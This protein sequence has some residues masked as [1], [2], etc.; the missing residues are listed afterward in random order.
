M[1]KLPKSFYQRS[2][3][4]SAKDFL[5]KYLVHKTSRGII[6][7]MITEV[8]AYPAFSDEVSHGNKRTGR[9][10][11]LYKEGGYA[12]VYLVYGL[13][14]QFALVVN[15]KDTP[16]VVFIRALEP[17]EGVGLMQHN[18]GK[19]I[20][21]TKLTASPG[22]LCKAFGITREHCGIDVTGDTLFIEDHGIPIDNNDIFEGK[23]IGI[24][25][26]LKG[27]E[28]ALRFTLKKQ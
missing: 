16:E 2:A 5:G 21:I 1:P 10:E 3:A 14:H 11:V 26:R 9:T 13:H 15:K 8:E 28:N 18:F 17:K 25:Q 12:Y 7:G 4:D 24:S 6:S 19:K 20:P 23:R 22:N 27:S